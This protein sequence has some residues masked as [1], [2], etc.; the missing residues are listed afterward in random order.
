M[1]LSFSNSRS[2]LA[3]S[4]LALLTLAHQVQGLDRLA[5][6]FIVEYADVSAAVGSPTHLIT[7]PQ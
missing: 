6:G 3:S 7:L 1:I 4:A 2:L 5:N